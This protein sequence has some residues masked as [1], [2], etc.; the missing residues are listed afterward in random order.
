MAEPGH[1]T[2]RTGSGFACRLIS[3][4]G[5]KPDL[6]DLFFPRVFAPASAQEILYLQGSAGHFQISQTVSLFVPSDLIY[7]GAELFSILRRSHTNFQ[8]MEEFIHPFQLQRRSKPAWKQL[9]PA[10][11]P[12]NLVL[13]DL[14]G[15]QVALHR[16][17]PADRYILQKSLPVLP[18]A[19]IHAPVIQQPAQFFQKLSPV[20]SLLVHLIDK[21]KCGHPIPLQQ[22]PERPGMSLDAV[23]SADHQHRVIDHLQRPFHLRGK[24]HMPRRIQKRHR[25]FP[26][27]K[28]RLL[29]KNRNPPIPLQLISIQERVPVVHTSQAADRAAAVEHRFRERSL[30]RVHMGE[31]ADVDR[32]LR[33]RS[34]IFIIRRI[35]HRNT[36]FRFMIVYP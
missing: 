12:V 7:S 27:T 26:Q 1:G 21:Q 36:P 15:P 19:K 13:R 11:Q 34:G 23:R 30:A 18:G 5:I 24:I 9:S 14:S 35:S 29:G 25:L 22:F 33:S 3:G 8:T 6:V 31:D 20:C 32:L 2:D 17:F 10:D 28:P 16:F 4:A